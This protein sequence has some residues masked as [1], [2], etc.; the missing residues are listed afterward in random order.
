MISELDGAGGLIYE[1]RV[2]APACA[3]ATSIPWSARRSRHGHCGAF[4]TVKIEAVPHRT[5]S[6]QYQFRKSVELNTSSNRQSA[7]RQRLGCVERA[8]TYIGS[9]MPSLWSDGVITS[10]GPV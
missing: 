10:C 9:G 6:H 8:Q 3:V 4:V 7:A 5:Q 2:A 1:G